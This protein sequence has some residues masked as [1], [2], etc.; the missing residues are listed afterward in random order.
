MSNTDS[1][2]D[3]VTEEVRRDRLFALMRKY[4]WIAILGVLLIVGGTIWNEWRKARAEASAQA[5]GDALR[6]ALGAADPTAALAA[7]PAEGDAAAVKGL[8]ASA[9]GLQAGDEAAALTALDGVA[10]DP[11]APASLRQLAKLK[12]VILSG[13][14]MPAVDREAILAELA[15]PGAPFRALALEQQALGLV[16]AGDAPAAI[17]ALKALLQEPGAT[18]GLQARA[19]QLI[20]ALGSDPLGQ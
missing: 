12:S 19:S 20:V 18:A 8:L 15:M 3:E 6:A 1:F 10:A 5:Y 17:V 16:A 4:G 14:S 13:P 11:G 2:I 9:V 7:L